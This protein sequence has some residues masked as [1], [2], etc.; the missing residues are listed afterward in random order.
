VYLS[1]VKNSK[2]GSRNI[3]TTG[4]TTG[5]N[6]DMPLFLNNSQAFGVTKE[7]KE[8]TCFYK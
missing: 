6:K 8:V 1:E 7:V 4:N 2:H 5:M 3:S